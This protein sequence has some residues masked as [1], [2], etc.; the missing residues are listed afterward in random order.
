[1]YSSGY[2][3]LLCTCRIEVSVHHLLHDVKKQTSSDDDDYGKPCRSTGEQL[4]E[5]K[6]HVLCVQKWPVERLE[7]T[8]PMSQVITQFIFAFYQ[9]ILESKHLE[10]TISCTLS[11]PHTKTHSILMQKSSHTSQYE[12]YPNG[13]HHFII[14][15]Q[16]SFI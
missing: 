8:K 9:S 1:M 11:K 16:K 6:V 5:H 4:H 12:F 2:L 3:C 14:V 7:K 10:C 13:S 15:Q